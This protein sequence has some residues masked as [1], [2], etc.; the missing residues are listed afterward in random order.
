MTKTILCATA[1]ASLLCYHIEAIGGQGPE[2]DCQ[3]RDQ[4]IAFNEG[5]N[6]ASDNNIKPNPYI[7]SNEEKLAY[8]F[9]IGWGKGRMAASAYRSAEKWDKALMK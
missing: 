5:Y 8:C 4:K 6:S 2:S 3:T 7:R 1:C 9:Q